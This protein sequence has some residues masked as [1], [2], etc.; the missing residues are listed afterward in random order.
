MRELTTDDEQALEVF[1]SAL[2]AR[3]PVAD[4]PGF[5]LRNPEAWARRILSAIARTLTEGKENSD[6]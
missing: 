4:R 2:S 1:E 5:H 6:G 3:T